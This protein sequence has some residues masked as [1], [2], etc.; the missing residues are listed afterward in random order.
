MDGYSF[1]DI[2]DATA[3]FFSL[4]ALLISSPL[5]NNSNIT[6]S[7][8]F[9]LSQVYDHCPRLCLFCSNKQKRLPQSNILLSERCVG[10]EFLLRFLQLLEELMNVILKVGILALSMMILRGGL[11]FLLFNELQFLCTH[12]LG[13]S[14]GVLLDFCFLFEESFDSM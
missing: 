8:M 4:D 13:I 5:S 9:F 6:S 3:A 14:R 7:F 10:D 11:R 1:S 2:I 12:K